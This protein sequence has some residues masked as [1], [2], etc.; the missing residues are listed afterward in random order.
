MSGYDDILQASMREIQKKD[1]PQTD[2]DKDAWA[3][4]KT[5][6]KNITEEF[7]STATA[8]VSN[9]PFSLKGYLDVQSR[10]L[11][12]SAR[13]GLLIF[14]QNKDARQ[15][16]DFDYWKTKGARVK[17]SPQRIYLME[18]NGQREWNGR[19]YNNYKTR[20]VFN[21]TQTTAKPPP[22][23]VRYEDR[24][25]LSALINRASGRSPG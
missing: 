6:E 3:Q 21:V 17:R 18:P 14:Q 20:I 16:G 15:I 23:P 11:H 19:L 2:F 22:P 9:D 5:E 12:H 13:N 1:E 7:L 4:K 8:R 10:F 25:K 24:T